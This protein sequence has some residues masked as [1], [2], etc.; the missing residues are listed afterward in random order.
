MSVLE[1]AKEDSG[2]DFRTK[3][4]IDSSSK[5]SF[6]SCFGYYKK[7][8]TNFALDAEYYTNADE[9]M[10]SLKKTEDCSTQKRVQV[11]NTYLIRK[12]SFRRDKYYYYRFNSF[13]F[14]DISGRELF[15]L[16]S[17]APPQGG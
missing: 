16:G 10:L 15:R 12:I 5:Q 11:P 6:N 3:R 13:A 1:R 2:L 17:K 8:V 9:T 4:S 14:F 7:N